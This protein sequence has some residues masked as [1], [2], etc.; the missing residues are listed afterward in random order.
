[1]KPLGVVRDDEAWTPEPGS[2]L[3]A[4]L[5]EL[6]SGKPERRGVPVVPEP[7][8]P[9]ILHIDLGAIAAA[10]G[11]ATDEPVVPM[12]PME[13]ELLEAARKCAAGDALQPPRRE[14]VAV[15]LREVRREQALR[16]RAGA[17]EMQ[18]RHQL[19][20]ARETGDG[21]LDLYYELVRWIA[22]AHGIEATAAAVMDF[23]S[24]PRRTQPAANAPAADRSRDDGTDEDGARIGA[25]VG[26]GPD[27]GRGACGV[28]RDVAGGAVRDQAVHHA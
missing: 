22:A 4:R 11:A 10:V 1:M 13:A 18:L 28:R 5:A 16:D 20:A 25:A 3:M 23:V 21:L 15:A 8:A 19:R 7:A 24:A 12:S 26:A 6:R 27:T 9:G 2:A 14:L 17:T